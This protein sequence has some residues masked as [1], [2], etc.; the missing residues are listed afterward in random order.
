MSPQLSQ[1][2]VLSFLFHRKLFTKPVTALTG[3]VE[4]VLS[5]KELYSKVMVRVESLLKQEND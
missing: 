2:G 1:R 4:P 5:E 3:F